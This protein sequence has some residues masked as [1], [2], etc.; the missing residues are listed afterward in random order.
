MHER[1][2]AHA[3]LREVARL[4]DGKGAVQV[5]SVRVTMG[6]FSGIEPELFRG[7]FEELVRESAMDDAKL[8]LTVA[9][10]EARCEACGEE[11]LVRRFQFQCPGCG[12]ARTTIV[13]GQELLLES[14]TMECHE[15]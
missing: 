1:S 12:H 6:E 14:V 2:L 15:P 10:L 5:A 13:R 3:L 8:I 9:P 7:A 11:F 4:V